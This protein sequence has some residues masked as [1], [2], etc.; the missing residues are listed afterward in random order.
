M[1]PIHPSIYLQVFV[2]IFSTIL[3]WWLQIMIWVN[4]YNILSL[5]KTSGITKIHLCMLHSMFQPRAREWDPT[6]W[7]FENKTTQGPNININYKLP[8]ENI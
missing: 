8:S 1:L 3:Y 7:V 6:Y 2:N 4:C 5:W